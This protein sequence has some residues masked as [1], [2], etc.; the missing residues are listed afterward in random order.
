MSMVVEGGRVSSKRRIPVHW[1]PSDRRTFCVIGKRRKSEH[2]LAYAT[3][4]I[5]AQLFRT[6]AQ[7]VS[8]TEEAS[9][10]EP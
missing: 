6:Y 10:Q 2:V 8:L 1:T 3:L 5:G 7:I 9:K 4:S